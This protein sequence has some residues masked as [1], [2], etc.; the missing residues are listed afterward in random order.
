[1]VQQTS[2]TTPA[3]TLWE[4]PDEVWPRI[5][6]ILNGHY[7]AKPKGHRRVDLRRGLNG[8]ICRLRTGCPWHH[9][10]ARC[11]DESPVHR[12]FQPWCQRG[13]LARIGAVLVASCD[14]LGGVDGPWQAA[15]TA[16]GKARMGGDLV[17]RHPT[18][19]G[20]R[21]GNGA[22]WLRRRGARGEPPSP[23]PRSMTPSWWPPLSRPWSWSAPCRPRSSPSTSAWTRAM[24]IPQ[25]MKRWRH[26]N[27]PH[28]SGVSVRRSLIPTA[29][30][31]TRR[32]AGWWNGH[33]PGSPSA[34][35]FS[36]V[37]RR[38]RSSS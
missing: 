11:G 12:H 23:G 22:S 15:D 19:R 26:S 4:I 5:Q 1:M 16:R 20:T 38:R 34:E 25:G 17:G 29:R 13:I 8:I 35:A 6:P 30:R 24:T 18:D 27:T 2:D 14:A 33:W 3:P 37:L 28:I 7:P 31:A 9:L 32:A 21:G 36:S 10:P